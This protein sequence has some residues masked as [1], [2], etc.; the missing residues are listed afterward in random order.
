MIPSFIIIII[1]IIPFKDKQEFNWNERSLAS[2]TKKKT[3]RAQLF[4]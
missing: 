2:L 3:P 1:I 4:L